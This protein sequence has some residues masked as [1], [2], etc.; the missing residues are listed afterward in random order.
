MASTFVNIYR[1]GAVKKC[2]KLEYQFNPDID[3]YK[4]C[5]TM[6]TSEQAALVAVEE[7]YNSIRNDEEFY[8]TDFGPI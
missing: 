4:G 1:G 7:L 6:F 2:G 5:K 3:C 8:D